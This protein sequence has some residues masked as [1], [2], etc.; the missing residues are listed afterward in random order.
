MDK[1]SLV[2]VPEKS[3]NTVISALKNTTIRGKKA[4]VRRERF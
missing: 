2:E 3:A 1:F 4:N